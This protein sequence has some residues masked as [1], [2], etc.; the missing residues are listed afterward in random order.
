MHE[1]YIYCIEN[2]VTHMKYV[3]QTQT[4]VEKRWKSHCNASKDSKRYTTYLYQSMRLHGTKSFVA[5]E[6]IKIV[7]PTANE[8]K[9]KLNEYEIF[10]ISEFSTLFP[11]GYNMTEGGQ[12]LSIPAS[13]KVIKVDD[14]GCVIAKF[15]SIRDAAISSNVNEKSVWYACNRS[16]THFSGGY[17]WYY[18]SDLPV[19]LNTNIGVQNRGKTN[20]KGHRTYLGKPVECYTKDGIYVDTFSSAT[21]AQKCLGINQTRISECCCGKKHRKTA[22]GY[23]WRFSTHNQN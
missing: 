1:G 21:Q 18:A 7:A 23:I 9:N 14:C 22:G 15:N 8:L 5:S 16:K 2:T 17:F 13:R 10:Y 12:V 3:G 6:I 20:W 11:N 4:T 19:D